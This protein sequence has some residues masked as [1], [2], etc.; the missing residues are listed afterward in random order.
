MQVSQVKSFVFAYDL[1]MLCKG[2]DT[3][4]IM[5]LQ[6]LKLFSATMLKVVWWQITGSQL[7]SLVGWI[8]ILLQ[9]LQTVLVSGLVLFH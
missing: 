7:P 3:S 1:I 4:I 5:L 2:E 6:G 9:G 8:M